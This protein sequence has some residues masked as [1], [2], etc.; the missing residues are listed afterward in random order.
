MCHKIGVCNILWWN[1]LCRGI[2]PRSRENSRHLWDDPPQMKQELQS[3]LGAVNY[4]QIFI[5]HLS[6]NTEPLRALLKKDNCFAWDENT[7]IC[8]QKI[9][10]T[11]E[12][13]PETPEILWSEQTSHPPV[14]CL[15]QGARSLHHPGWK[16]HCFCKQAPHGHWDPL[17][18]HWERILG[19]CIWLWEIPH[20]PVRKDIH[21]G[22]RP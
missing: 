10:P 19:H 13:P 12:S 7:N 2:L 6:S 14:W 16:A 15:T 3:F 20:V 18:Q 4:L 21:H 1:L 5:P 22:D 8:F 9:V 11:A 17:C